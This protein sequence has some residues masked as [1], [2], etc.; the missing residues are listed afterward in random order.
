[1]EKHLIGIQSISVKELTNFIHSIFSRSNFCTT[2]IRVT[3]QRIWKLKDMLRFFSL[4]N[5]NVF[6]NEIHSIYLDNHMW[7]VICY[8]QLGCI[9]G[10]L[11]KPPQKI[12]FLILGE[13]I[14]FLYSKWASEMTNVIFL[15]SLLLFTLAIG[16]YFS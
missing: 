15:F 4:I 13:H 8:R 1:M 16:R 7:H 12:S 14:L 6:F 10:I 5:C 9:Q 2:I 3:N 11:K